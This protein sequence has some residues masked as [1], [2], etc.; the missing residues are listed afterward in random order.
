MYTRE[1][2]KLTSI[3]GQNGHCVEEKQ[4]VAEI[5]WYMTPPTPSM[6]S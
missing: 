3:K 6:H 5:A 4:C 1:I 2:Y